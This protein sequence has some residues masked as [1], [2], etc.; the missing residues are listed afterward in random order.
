MMM[1]VL[2]GCNSKIEYIT[3]DL[4]D[5]HTYVVDSNLSID[6]KVKYAEE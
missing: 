3:H 6:Y 2:T 1:L 4:P 5:L